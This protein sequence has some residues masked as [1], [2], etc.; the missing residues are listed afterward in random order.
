MGSLRI[1]VHMKEVHS[2]RVPRSH[3]CGESIRLG[4]QD[5]LIMI[6]MMVSVRYF[7]CHSIPKN[8]LRPL[9]P[10]TII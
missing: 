3:S 6:I 8:T 4:V 1:P 9:V 7:F 5:A 2:S 10:E